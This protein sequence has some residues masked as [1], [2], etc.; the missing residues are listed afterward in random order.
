MA[1][2]LIVAGAVLL[3]VLLALVKGGIVGFSR[4]QRE[5]RHPGSDPP[6]TSG[7]EG[8]LLQRRKDDGVGGEGG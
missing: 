1:M 4:G 8:E 2:T 5:R 7:A 3:L 6:G